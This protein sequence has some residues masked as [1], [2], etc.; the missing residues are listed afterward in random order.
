M[1]KMNITKLTVLTT[2]ALIIAACGSSK[3]STTSTTPS[4]SIIPSTNTETFVAPNGIHAP[5]NEELTA[6]QVQHK[7]VTL[8]QLNEGYILY[9]QG[10]CVNC[11]KAKN[12]YSRPE[13]Q[14]EPIINDMAV[15]AQLTS[16][17]KE[18]VYNYVLS[19]KATQPK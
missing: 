3:K 10:A 18:A 16:S 12:I 19:I 9:T 4:T 7:D 1:R 17:Q 14:W 5:G 13:Y 2:T 15:K 8:E 11:H 6:I